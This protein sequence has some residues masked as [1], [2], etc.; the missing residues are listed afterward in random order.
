MSA[1]RP[2]ALRYRAAGNCLFLYRGRDAIIKRL[3]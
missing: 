1:R 2:G 3:Q